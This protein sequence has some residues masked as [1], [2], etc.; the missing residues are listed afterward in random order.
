MIKTHIFNKKKLFRAISAALIAAIIL[1]VP[2]DSMSAFASS[3]QKKKEEAE[4]G[5]SETTEKINEIQI[6]QNE[7]EGEISDAE[8]DLDALLVQQET[9]RGEIEDTQVK[10]EQ[11]QEELAKAKETEEKQYESMKLRIQYMY[12]ND[13]GQSFWSAILESEGIADFLN[14]I[15]YIL[16]MH[17]SDRDLMKEYEQAV[18]DVQKKTDEL[19][20][21]MDELLA[22]QEIYL[23]QQAEVEEL[24]AGL[25]DQ[26]SRYADQLAEAQVLAAAYQKTI[27]EQNLII[28]EQLR[29]EEEER[30]RKEEEEQKRKEEEEQKRQEE[31]KKKQEANLAENST[32]N[33]TGS[34]NAAAGG[35]NSSVTGTDVVNYALQFVGNPYVWGGNSLT[36]GCD[37]SGFVHLVYAHFG[38]STPR[39]SQDFATV[40]V[41]VSESEMQPG[42]IIVY[43]PASGTGVGH[44]AIYIG[45]GKI[46]EAQSTKAGITCNRAYNSRTIKAIRRVL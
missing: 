21:Q 41:A 29:K 28:E 32:T 37:C 43:P 36:N 26:K 15:E 14:R 3:A 9:L 22:R 31:E 25:A 6:E 7:L 19:A 42:D 8:K 17:N 45:N 34:N 16:E 27:E 2:A 40:G 39:Y 33:N 11:T 20:E 24:L 35:S 4:Q 5:L 1:T 18:E 23:G 12:E 44:V 30:K 46:V 13:T 38:I 10:V